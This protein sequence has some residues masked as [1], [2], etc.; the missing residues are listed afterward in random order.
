VRVHH[1]RFVVAALLVSAIVVQDHTKSEGLKSKQALTPTVLGAPALKLAE[2]YGRVP[3]SFEPNQGQT[4]RRVQFLSRGSGY[5]LFLTRTEAV[6]ALRPRVEAES[7]R[8]SAPVA[9]HRSASSSNRGAILRMQLLGSNPAAS[10]IGLDELRGKSNYFTSHD[11]KRWRTNVPNYA[12]VRFEDVYRG[13]DLVYYG[14]QRQLEYDFVVGAGANPSAIRLGFVGAERLE[15]DSQGELRLQT[16]AGEV[17]WHKP[18]V[19]QEI[20]G[21]RQMVDGHYLRKGNTAVGF[22][23]GAYDPHHALVIDPVLAFSTYLGGSGDDEGRAIAVDSSGNVY[24]TGTTVSADFPTSANAFQGAGGAFVTKLNPTDGTLVYSTYL[25]VSAQGQSIAV[26]STGSAYVAGGTNESEF[27]TVNA[28]QNVFGGGTTDAFVAKLNPSGNAL[29]YSTF[30]GGEDGDSGNG[31]AVDV[32]GQAYVAG[33]TESHNFPTVNALQATHHGGTDV[34][35]VK[36]NES[37]LPIYSTYLGGSGSEV[38]FGIA[39]D[40]FLGNAYVT[41]DTDSTDFPRVNALQNARSG[42]SDAFIAKLSESGS[43]LV[44]STY[45]GGGGEDQARGIAVDLSGDAYV[46]GVTDSNDFPTKNAFQNELIGTSAGFVTR[47]NQSGNALVYSSYLGGHGDDNEAISIAADPSNH[48]YITGFTTSRDFPVTSNAFSPGFGLGFGHAYVAKFNTND[49]GVQSLAYSSYLGG[50]SFDEG[51]GIAVDPNGNVYVTGTTNSRD[52]PVTDDAFQGSLAGGTDAFVAK[53]SLGPTWLNVSAHSP[54]N[55]LLTNEA[56]HRTGFDAAA[57]TVV[58][59]ISGGSYTGPGSE[60]QTVRVPYAPGTYLLDAFGLDSLTSPEPYSL[61][62]AVTDANGNILDR[63]DLNGLASRGA[64]YR[65]TFAIGNG[66]IVPTPIQPSDTTPP[67]IGCSAPDGQ[68]HGSDV[69]LACT[70]NDSQSALANPADA[71]FLLSTHVAAGTE[72]DNASTDSRQVC[73]QAGNCASAGPIVGNKV[74]RKPPTIVITAPTGTYVL[75]QAVAASYSCTDGGSGVASC[76]GD[77]PN[78]VNI[79][80]SAAGMASLTVQSIDR[81]G[82]S[83]SS[84]ARYVV[85][86]SISYKVCPLYDSNSAKKSGSTYPIKIQLCDDRGNN[87]SSPS[88]VM[89]A[90]GVT[91]TSTNTPVQ[92]DDTG[93]AN[94]DSDFRYDSSLGGYIFNLS[95]KGFRTGTYSLRFTAGLDPETHAVSFAVK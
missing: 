61:T 13:V 63:A 89:H 69:V 6:M 90:V 17:R 72:T 80:T 25:G 18:V 77:I 54:V 26:D 16:T 56:G 46:T 29:V 64:D 3:L 45:L 24:V 39:V 47:L 34:F 36:L 84:V 79:N 57:G 42:F 71:S 4:D 40:Y 19:Y 30:L 83:A 21:V 28:I 58:G 95:T 33:G 15:I 1:T 38:A 52:F 65:F 75:G 31:I 85:V 27:P 9:R 7:F 14:N 74:D 87:L 76:S 37:G 91:M 43:V 49:A 94:P 2:T 92:F 93:N 59:E 66:P 11:P 88:I 81:A 68:W 82:N 73:D 35:V 20:G 55:I 41:G 67:T 10:V 48:A 70:A 50:T 60:P 78:G 23:V 12:R 86:S 8:S 5:S 22:E 32:F 51:N 62:F 53:I 44:Y